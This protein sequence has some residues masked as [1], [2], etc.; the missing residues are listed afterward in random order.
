MI[1]PSAARKGALALCERWG[2]S[3]LTG[4]MRMTGS[5]GN[6]V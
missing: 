2:K 6:A 1:T 5:S 4:E 3:E